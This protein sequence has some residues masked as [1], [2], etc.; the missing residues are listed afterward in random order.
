MWILI[1]VSFWGEP[2][3]AQVEFEASY[4]EE[5]VCEHVRDDFNVKHHEL[6]IRE[7]CVPG[8]IEEDTVI[9][10]GPSSVQPDTVIGHEPLSVQP[11][12]KGGGHPSDEGGKL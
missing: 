6:R 2:N 7:V 9:G 3:T 8:S 12:Q 11:D 5:A 4:A 10:H 1:A